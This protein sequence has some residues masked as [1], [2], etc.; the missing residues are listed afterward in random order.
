MSRSFRIGVCN[1]PEILANPP[2]DYRHLNVV[3]TPFAA[4][5]GG[6][7]YPAPFWTDFAGVWLFKWYRAVW[8]LA[9][10]DARSAR[11]P[12]WYTY[13]MWLRR[14]TK[15][16]WRLSFVKCD[17]RNREVAHESLVIPE[18]VEG[19]I[20]G[21]AHKL[22]DGARAAGVWPADCAAL[23]DLLAG[24]GEYL[25]DLE[26]GVIPP[27]HFLTAR[28]AVPIP[29]TALPSRLAS[30]PPLP[31]VASPVVVCP[32]CGAALGPRARGVGPRVCDRCG[33]LSG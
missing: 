33:P 18:V 12:F 27:P 11:L 14:T 32:R 1:D 10:G 9:E 8:Q 16:W 6:V 19:A 13:E 7:D 22:L 5:A 20:V 17:A 23:A 26:A 28:F 21:A 29:G 24:R 25:A 2:P 30:R 31:R 4:S 3:F 15:T